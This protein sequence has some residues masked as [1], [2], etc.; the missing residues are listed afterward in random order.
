MY[1]T[2]MLENRRF[3]SKQKK[4]GEIKFRAL[5]TINEK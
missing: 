1:N 4:I 3:E 5:Q 2:A